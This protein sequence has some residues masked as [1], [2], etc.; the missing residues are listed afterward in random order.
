MQVDKGGRER[1]EGDDFGDIIDILGVDISLKTLQESITA[2][3]ID[4]LGFAWDIWYEKL[5]KYKEQYGDCNVPKNKKLAVWVSVQRKNYRDKI[6]GADR[7]KR[8]EDIDFVLDIHELYWEER[9]DEL[10]KYNE[11]YGDCNVPTDWKGSEWFSDW[12]SAQRK[13]YRD[14][15]L[16]VDRIKRLEGIDFFFDP[17]WEEMFDALVKHQH[18]Y[19][20]CNVPYDYA[21]KGQLC[22]WIDEQRAFYRC[23]KLSDKQIDLLEGIGIVWIK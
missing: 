4:K 22:D 11:Q 14:K 9:F 12:I 20:D 23:G 8:L 3:C 2:V 17:I 10:V 6:L 13:N 5:A 19:G 15:K 21:I 18:M 16:S 7:I 1:P